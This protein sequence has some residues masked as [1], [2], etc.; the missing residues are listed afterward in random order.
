[1][2]T[3]SNPVFA[4]FEKLT[5]QWSAVDGLYSPVTFENPLFSLFPP[6]WLLHRYGL[7]VEFTPAL[8]VDTTKKPDLSACKTRSIPASCS[9]L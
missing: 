4:C 3:E 6:V 1:M 7:A 2:K 9:T 8:P 5:K